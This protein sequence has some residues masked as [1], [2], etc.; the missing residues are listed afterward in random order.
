MN[1]CCK[2]W[3]L[4][5]IV[6]L[7]VLGFAVWALMAA[8]PRPQPRMV[9]SYSVLPI[10]RVNPDTGAVTVPVI[11]GY[12]GPAIQVGNMVPIRGTVSVLDDGQVQVTQSIV[13]EEVPRGL[14]VV[15]DADYTSILNPGVT[16]LVFAEKIPPEVA[17]AI[18]AGGAHLWRIVSV[19][20]VNEPDALDAGWTT[21]PFWIVP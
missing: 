9:V 2:D 4:V 1:R 15:S 18:N 8:V 13:W 10:E 6:A 20:D 11:A 3:L 19:V 14:R 16:R 7:L 21:A 12:D 17:E 5:P